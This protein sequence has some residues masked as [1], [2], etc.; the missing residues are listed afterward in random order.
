MLFALTAIKT[1]K[2]V[3]GREREREG[4]F[5]VQGVC[6]K[7]SLPTNPIAVQAP[8]NFPS[9]ADLR[10]RDRKVI[11]VGAAAAVVLVDVD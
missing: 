5:L 7:V 9:V 1:R 8:F 2:R 10:K 3:A 4:G 11:V 6:R